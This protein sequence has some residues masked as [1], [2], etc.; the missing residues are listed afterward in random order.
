MPCVPSLPDR[1]LAKAA[2]AQADGWSQLW[3]EIDEV[4]IPA[5]SGLLIGLDDGSLM[6]GQVLSHWQ[7]FIARGDLASRLGGV[8]TTRAQRIGAALSPTEQSEESL[9]TTITEAVS[10]SVHLAVRTAMEQVVATW[11][12]HLYGS[13][14]L[15]ARGHQVT[16]TDREA[17]LAKPVDDWRRMVTDQVKEALRKAREERPDL[18]A[19]EQTVVDVV[20]AVAVAADHEAPT[21]VKLPSFG[22]PEDDSEADSAPGSSTGPSVLEQEPAA[23]G[24]TVG[25]RLAVE[26]LLGA[27]VVRSI[28]EAARTDLLERAGTVIDNEQLRLERVLESP[29]GLGLRVGAL[30]DAASTVNIAE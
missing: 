8:T 13:G 3:E 19:D 21:E 7:E 24:S 9:T 4:F 25:A 28:V 15:T 16:P 6:S 5:R 27:D 10:A 14:L 1:V 11:R 17:M 18:S 22:Q 30:L 12:K 20:F 23:P 26:E 2:A 29:E